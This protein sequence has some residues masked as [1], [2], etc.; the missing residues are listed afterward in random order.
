VGSRLRTVSRSTSIVMPRA[1]TRMVSS[2]CMSSAVEAGTMA[3]AF[4]RMPMRRRCVSFC[5]SEPGI[6]TAASR[7]YFD[8]APAAM[9]QANAR[10]A[11]MSCGAVPSRSERFVTALLRAQA[12]Q[13]VAPG[14]LVLAQEAARKLLRHLGWAPRAEPS[15]P[16]GPPAGEEAWLAL[17]DALASYPVYATVDGRCRVWSPTASRIGSAFRSLACWDQPSACVDA[18]ALLLVPSTAARECLVGAAEEKRDSGPGSSLV[19]ESYLAERLEVI[20][21]FG[22][23]KDLFSA[24]QQPSQVTLKLPRSAEEYV[25]VRRRCGNSGSGWSFT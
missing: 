4:S 20:Y 11:E 3:T 22:K 13:E 18:L 23:N 6:S 10:G 14:A 7:R 24:L 2:L 8:L 19:L 15:G 17:Q 9:T 1:A 25:V 21:T 12:A 5:S 16:G